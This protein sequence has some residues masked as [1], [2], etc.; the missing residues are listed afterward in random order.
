M[1][2][3]YT[4]QEDEAYDIS[5][6]QAHLNEQLDFQTGMSSKGKQAFVVYFDEEEQAP[7]ID[8]AIGS[9][10]FSAEAV[11]KLKAMDLRIDGL[12]AYTVTKEKEPFFYTPKGMNF[13]LDH[14][15]ATKAKVRGADKET[16]WKA[17]DKGPDGVKRKTVNFSKQELSAFADTI[18][19]RGEQL[20]G[21]KFFH[22]NAIQDMYL[23]GTKT[24]QD[25]LDYDFTMGWPE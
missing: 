17:A 10:D 12:E 18:I 2:K 3:T 7:A 9:Y 22:E 20:L 11:N 15:L 8:S 5:M 14:D 19:D 13:F 1:Q 21:V 6:L 23:D 24:Y 25:I 4:I 16:P